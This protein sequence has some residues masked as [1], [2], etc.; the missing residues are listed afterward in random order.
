M[1]WAGYITGSVVGAALLGLF[2]YFFVWRIKPAAAAAS[3]RPKQIPTGEVEVG[4][5]TIKQPGRP[6]V[7]VATPG[8]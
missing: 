8:F 3:Q 6:T 1:R 4:T 7:R 5:V 2:L